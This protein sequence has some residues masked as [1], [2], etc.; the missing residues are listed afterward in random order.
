MGRRNFAI[1]NLT[2]YK[3][4]GDIFY[5][6]FHLLIFS[7]TQHKQ[8]F[9]YTKGKSTMN[10]TCIKK[11]EK[12]ANYSTYT[13]GTTFLSFTYSI[14]NAPPPLNLPLRSNA[15]AKKA[16]SSSLRFVFYL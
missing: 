6:T 11:V 10:P 1:S 9:I 2:F 13:K 3:Y 16:I 12:Q 8:T 4:A 7:Y 14:G 5:F 15:V